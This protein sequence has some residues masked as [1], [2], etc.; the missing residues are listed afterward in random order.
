MWLLHNQ[1]IRGKV[2][3]NYC[4]TLEFVPDWYMTQKMCDKDVNIHPSTIEYVPDQ[5]K[6]QE[7]CDKAADKFVFDSDQ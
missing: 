4:W 3:D 5:F 6:D 7:M 2:V 1:Q